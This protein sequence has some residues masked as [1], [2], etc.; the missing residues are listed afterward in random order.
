MPSNERQSKR[1]CLVRLTIARYTLAENGKPPMSE[2]STPNPQAEPPRQESI[3]RILWNLK[4]YVT[5]AVGVYEFIRYVIENW[6]SELNYLIIAFVIAYGVG[7]MAWAFAISYMVLLLVIFIPMGLFQFV[8]SF[9]S[10]SLSR[11]IYDAFENTPL[12]VAW[13]L[14]APAVLVG[15]LA[16]VGGWGSGFELLFAITGVPLLLM[17]LYRIVTFFY[18]ICQVI[19]KKVETLTAE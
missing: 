2:R 1:R 6:D 5:A 14:V 9:I 19:Q 13:A 8:T 7:L 15:T 10:K 4:E 18:R 12:W 17:L 16:V 11:K 3:F